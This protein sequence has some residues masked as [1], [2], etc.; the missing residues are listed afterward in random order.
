MNFVGFYI[1]GAPISAV[2]AL[3]DYVTTSVITKMSFCVAAT[4]IAQ[5]CIA[6]FGYLFLLRMDWGKAAAI[7]KA[8]AHTDKTESEQTSWISSPRG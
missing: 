3:S 6:V 8:R 4:A 5:T 1:I 7:I 2:V